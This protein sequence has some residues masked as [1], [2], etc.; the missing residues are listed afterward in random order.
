MDPIQFRQQF[1]YEEHE[2]VRVHRNLRGILLFGFHSLVL[3]PYLSWKWL[4]E[5]LH[6]VLQ[7]THSLFGRISVRMRQDCHVL[8]GSAYENL[9]TEHLVPCRRAQARS[10]CISKLAAKRPWATMVDLE[11]LLEGW[12]MGEAYA[13][14]HDN[15]AF[16]S[17]HM[18]SSTQAS[19]DYI[20]STN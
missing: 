18:A 2:G 13:S 10:A 15:P 3:Y 16:C 17:G 7:E 8:L 6:I 1:F 12:D 19:A 4:V 11:I 9:A 20:P 14:P 5:F